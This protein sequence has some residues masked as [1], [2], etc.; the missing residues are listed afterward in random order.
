MADADQRLRELPSVDDVL[1]ADAAMLAVARFGRHAVVTALRQVL[2]G[3]GGCLADGRG[4]L[5]G[6]ALGDYDPVRAGAGRGDGALHRQREG[7]H[8]GASA[9]SLTGAPDADI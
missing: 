4:D 6:S 8:P 5:R 2:D 1:K 7:A 9:A 3:P